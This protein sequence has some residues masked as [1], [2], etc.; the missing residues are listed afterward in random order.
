MESLV[1]NIDIRKIKPVKKLFHNEKI[2][3]YFLKLP[4]NKIRYWP[5]NLRTILAF[6]QLEHSQ[7]KKL[8][9]ITL[10][11][12]TLLLA[13]R[14]ELKLTKLAESIEN[15]GVRVPLIILDDGTLLDGNRRYFSCSYVYHKLKNKDS[16]PD[17]L[18]E[19]PVWVIKKNEITDTQ[20]HKILAE[21]N[22]VPDFKVPWTLD[23][24]AEIISR[25]YNES[26]ESGKTE[27]EAY[28]EIEDVYGLKRSKVR[29]YVDTVALTKEFVATASGNKEKEFKLREQVLAK[30]V[31]FWEFRNKAFRGGGALDDN[32]ISEVKPLFFKM[33]ENGCFKNVKQIE[34]MI[35]SYHDEDL[36]NI[37]SDS[38][39]TKID[40]VEVLFREQKTIKSSEDKVRNF[41]KWLNKKDY[42]EFSRATHSLLDQ[43]VKEINLLK[44]GK[45]Q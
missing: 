26:L 17:I 36:W 37:L 9:E 25:L 24:Q 5:K 33:I 18:K 45:G 22:F 8:N 4:F 6:E 1:S 10:K 19:I 30:F 20:K 7:N 40:Q 34:P 41:L 2:D 32:E 12:I 44:S 28:F 31:Y 16:I 38:Q 13:S 43:L 39:G 23:V 11:E 15:N 14:P 21:A 42:N 3:T 35:R 27:E 29:E